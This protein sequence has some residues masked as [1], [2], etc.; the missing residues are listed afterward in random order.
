MGPGDGPGKTEAQPR[1]GLG[2][3]RVTAVKALKNRFQIFPENPHAVV[4]DRYLNR[5]ISTV[6]YGHIDLSIRRSVFN[7]IV[8]QIGNHALNQPYVAINA[9]IFRAAVNHG[10]AFILG[11]GLENITGITNKNGDIQFLAVKLIHTGLGPGNNQHGVDHVH[12]PVAFF[13]GA[14]RHGFVFFQGRTGSQRNFGDPANP[15]DGAFEVVGD[16]VAHLFDAGHQFLD[17]IQH[18]IKGQRQLINLICSFF[19][20]HPFFKTAF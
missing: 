1:A 11:R 19:H 6:R 13:N 14:G 16:V 2:P 18:L 5:L 10:E 3:A 17:A 8:E 4:F 7:G 20:R 12:K 15:G 9:D